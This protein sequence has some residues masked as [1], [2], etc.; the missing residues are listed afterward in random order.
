MD[1]FNNPYLAHME[2]NGANGYNNGTEKV[3]GLPGMKRH[4]TTAELAAKLED[5]PHN[6]FTG[7]QLS[8]RY[9]SILKTR[10]NL[11]VNAQR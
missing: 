3:A 4:N 8:S 10:R 11:P 9:F 7:K 1:S 6:P 2:E 5:G